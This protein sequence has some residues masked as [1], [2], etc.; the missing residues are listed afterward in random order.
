MEGNI[1]VRRADEFLEILK[2][3]KKPPSPVSPEAS[4]G[5][6]ARARLGL[7]YFFFRM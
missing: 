1:Q 7:S 6:W 5:G 2:P 3:T 4:D